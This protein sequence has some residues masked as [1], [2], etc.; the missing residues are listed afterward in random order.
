MILPNVKEQTDSSKR[1]KA[2]TTDIRKK[3]L[4]DSGIELLFKKSSQKIKDGH[5]HSNVDL[6]FKTDVVLDNS[7][8]NAVDG[9]KKWNPF[10]SIKIYTDRRKSHDVDR[11]C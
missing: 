10:D 11:K 9:D 1:L 2:P 5:H 8:G 7:H 4:I 3:S 6:K